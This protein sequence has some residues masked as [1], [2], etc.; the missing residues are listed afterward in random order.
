V[1]EFRAQVDRIALKDD[2]F[3]RLVMQTAK[4]IVGTQKQ[5]TDAEQ[6][7]LDYLRTKFN[8]GD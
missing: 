1:S 4:E 6:E 3:K 8:L 7:A 5:V 2:A